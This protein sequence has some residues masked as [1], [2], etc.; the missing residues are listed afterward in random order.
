MGN[1]KL[2]SAAKLA[3]RS[4]RRLRLRNRDFSLISN[5][6][7]AGIIYHDLGLPFRTPTI[8]LFFENDDFFRFADNLEYY[9]TAGSRRYIKQEFPIRLGCCGAGRKP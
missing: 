3:Y 1:S 5:N 7:I 9:L 4:L 2:R 8:N 6:C